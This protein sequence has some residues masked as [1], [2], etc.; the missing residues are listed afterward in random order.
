MFILGVPNVWFKFNLNEYK[1][2]QRVDKT[3]SQTHN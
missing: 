2:Y 1:N 3:E